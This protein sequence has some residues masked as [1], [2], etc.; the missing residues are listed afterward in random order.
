MVIVNLVREVEN[1]ESMEN[2]FVIVKVIL[3]TSPNAI[4]SSLF[5]VMLEKVASTKVKLYSSSTSI[6]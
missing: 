4:L 6:K 3:D 2:P 1:E 5:A